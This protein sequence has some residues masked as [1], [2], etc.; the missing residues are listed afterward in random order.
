MHQLP[1][2]LPIVHH[3]CDQSLIPEVLF[4]DEGLDGA[5]KDHEEGRG[6][7]VLGEDQGAG[8]VVEEV[9]HAQELGFYCLGEF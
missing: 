4:T 6:G 2:V 9:A 5:A 7:F 8:G 3:P 1:K